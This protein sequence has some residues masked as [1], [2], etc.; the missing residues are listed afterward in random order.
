M[1]TFNIPLRLNEQ[2]QERLRLKRCQKN[3]YYPRD[4]Q[5]SRRKPILVSSF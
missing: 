1:H 3:N 4:R 5:T 2:L